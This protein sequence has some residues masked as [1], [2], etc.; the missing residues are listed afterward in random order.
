MR[1]MR[2]DGLDGLF[3]LISL[4]LSLAVKSKNTCPSTEGHVFFWVGW[5]KK[6]RF[7]CNLEDNS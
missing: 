3:G 2:R 5:G 7:I 6:T 1:T 4:F